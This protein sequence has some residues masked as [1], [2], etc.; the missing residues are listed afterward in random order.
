MAKIDISIET[1]RKYKVADDAAKKQGGYLVRI[2]YPY[3]SIYGVCANENIVRALL[4]I[5][6]ND[7]EVLNDYH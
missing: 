7:V 1:Y 5:C 3:H 6:A 4:T 2:N